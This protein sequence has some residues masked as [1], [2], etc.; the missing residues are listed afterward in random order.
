MTQK[1]V[2]LTGGT[3]YIASHTAVQL[4]QAGYNIVLVDNLVNSKKSVVDRLQNITAQNIPFYKVNVCDMDAL[5]PVFNAHDIYA[6]IH[7]ASLKAVGESVQYPERY[8]ANNIG[9]LE[10]VLAVMEHYG[11]YN[12]VFSS[13]ATVYGVPQYCP[14]DEL[15][16]LSAT[17]PYGETK[18]ACE[19]ILRAVQAENKNWHVA[20]LRYF[21]PI[22]AH[23]NGTLGEDPKG[24]PNN[25]APYVAKVAVGAL[26]EV[27][28]FGDDYDTVDG[29]GVRDYIHVMDLADGHVCALQ[30]I[31]K[32]HATAINLGTGQ[33]YSVLQVIQAFSHA[34]GADIKYAIHP[35]RAGDIAMC[36]ADST[37]AQKFMNWSTKYNIAHMAQHHLQWVQNFTQNKG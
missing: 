3:G 37:F 1:T 34:L 4:I 17:N 2:L 35:R 21:N 16:P 24:I 8:Y 23:P 12:L 27:R 13:S 19:E 33:G 5:Q 11:C 29:T 32:C 36:Y 7:F 6:V 20:L 9:G 26:P 10:S 22:G 30:H 18:I 15:H 28:V 25:L 14:I 31:E